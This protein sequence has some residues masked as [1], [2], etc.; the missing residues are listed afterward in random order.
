M[1][2][3]R[4]RCIKKNTVKPVFREFAK[5]TTVLAGNPHAP[6]NFWWKTVFYSFNKPYSSVG[7]SLVTQKFCIFIHSNSQNKRFSSGS[8]THIKNRFCSFQRKT[9]SRPYR[10]RIKIVTFQTT[11]TKFFRT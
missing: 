11:G 8:C 7:R 5:H 9:C 6:F 2:F 1:A 3:R 4:A 10:S